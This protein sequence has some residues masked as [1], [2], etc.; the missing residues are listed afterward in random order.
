MPEKSSPNFNTLKVNEQRNQI[1]FYL[2][3][4]QVG[5]SL[6][7]LRSDENVFS[8]CSDISFFVSR[9]KSTNCFKKT[10]SRSLWYVLIQD[11]V[12]EVDVVVPAEERDPLQAEQ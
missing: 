12:A 7:C 5:K 6:E 8:N 11:G 3:D 10:C 2:F 4:L 9:Q 1:D